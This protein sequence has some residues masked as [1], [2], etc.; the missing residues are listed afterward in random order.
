MSPAGR[1]PGS[2][3]PAVILLALLAFTAAL[4]AL[5]FPAGIYAVFHGGVS[6][7]MNA[8]SLVQTYLWVGPIPAFLPL[9]PVGATFLLLSGIYA[10]MF[11]FS[12]WQKPR[13]GTAASDALRTG[14]G[15]VLESPFFVIVV[16]IGFL[17][18]SGVAITDLSQWALGSVGNPFASFDPLREFVTLALAPMGEE[19]GFRVVLIGL[20]AFVLSVGRP[21]RTALKALWRPSV[22]F[23]G[24]GVGS[25]KGAVWGAILV[26]A[27]VFGLAHLGG[28]NWA[29]LPYAVWGG[30]V[31][32]YLYVRY[33]L[34]VAV[35]THWGVDYFGSAFA[36]Y[37]QSAYGIPAASATTQYFGQYLV[38]LDMGF[39]LGL[40]SFLLVTYLAVRRVLLARSD[41]QDGLV[42][43]G[44]KEGPPL[45]Q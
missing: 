29:K 33:G 18:F 17:S 36:Y 38:D 15:S 41:A 9:V 19:I 45:A 4:M 42:D 10:A 6:T 40:V 26:S 43:K 16:A 20:V 23:E 5:S 31:L 7:T 39:L 25:A 37:G 24:A 12:A 1:P 2:L 44:L 21:I 3:I 27:A 35:L 32:G 11:L 30:L 8:G 14:V 34:H 22:L 13:P 28:W